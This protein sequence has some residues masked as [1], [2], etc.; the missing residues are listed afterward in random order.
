MLKQC[1]IEKEKVMLSYMVNEFKD[2][3]ILWG[4]NMRIDLGGHN[5]RP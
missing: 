1:C 5:G 4:P 2:G 3:F